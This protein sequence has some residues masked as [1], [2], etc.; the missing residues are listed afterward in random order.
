MN[1]DEECRVIGCG[2]EEMKL[3]QWHLKQAANRLIDAE[4]E[5]MGDAELSE[6][7]LVVRRSLDDL[8][9]RCD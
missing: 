2:T 6:N 5:A 4:T 1:D 8:I 3:I 9:K 7:I